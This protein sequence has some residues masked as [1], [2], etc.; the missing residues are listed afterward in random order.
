M[1]RTGV[2]IKLNKKIKRGSPDV[3]REFLGVTR[4]KVYEP[5]D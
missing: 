3:T 1:N 2:K 5:L 4:G